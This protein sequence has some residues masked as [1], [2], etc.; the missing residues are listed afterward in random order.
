MTKA[1]G[2]REAGGKEARK[3]RAGWEPEQFSWPEARK[4]AV[5]TLRKA[6]SKVSQVRH[7]L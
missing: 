5:A 4:E 6:I 3:K 7:S 1:R 2:T